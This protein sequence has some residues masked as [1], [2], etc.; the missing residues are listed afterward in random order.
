MMMEVLNNLERRGEL[1]VLLLNGFISYKILVYRD[2]YLMYD[3]YRRQGFSVYEAMD[4]TAG[5]CDVS[6]MTVRR[7]RK[8]F[9]DEQ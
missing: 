8:I 4:W 9:E 6:I 7:V 2:I 5:K 3:A 1:K